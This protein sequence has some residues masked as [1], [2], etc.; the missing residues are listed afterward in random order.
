MTKNVYRESQGYV[1]PLA[2]NGAV[3]R[4]ADGN[5]AALHLFTRQH[6]RQP[7]RVSLSLCSLETL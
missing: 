3:G 6:P 2:T 5:Q 7:P 4:D 1:G